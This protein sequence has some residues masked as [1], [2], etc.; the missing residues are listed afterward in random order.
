EER[1]NT[2]Q[3][4]GEL[5][6]TPNDWVS[7]TLINREELRVASS[8]SLEVARCLMQCLP[9]HALWIHLFSPVDERE[10]RLT[11][12][13]ISPRE[14]HYR[15]TAGEKGIHGS[16]VEASRNIDTSKF[17]VNDVTQ[18]ILQLAGKQLEK[19]GL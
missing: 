2:L 7:D 18:Y 3:F 19:G 6:A 11:A 10:R 4:A 15:L 5:Y 17:S 14:L 12:R 1:I 8:P 9:R 16:L 13:G